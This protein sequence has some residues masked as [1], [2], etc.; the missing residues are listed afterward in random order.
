[1][2]IDEFD[3]YIEAISINFCYEDGLFLMSFTD[4]YTSNVEKFVVYSGSHEFIH[5]IKSADNIEYYLDDEYELKY[6]AFVRQFRNV[7]EWA[8]DVIRMDENGEIISYNPH[9]SDRAIKVSKNRE[10]ESSD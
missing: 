6:N 7:R 8:E 9:L 10:Y 1:M 4:E 5:Y 3:K 2:E